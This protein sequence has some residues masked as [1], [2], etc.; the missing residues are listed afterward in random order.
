MNLVRNGEHWKFHKT[1]WCERGLI[2]SDIGT[3]NVREDELNTIL[4]YSMIRLENLQKAC[5]RGV[6]G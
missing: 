6:T 2:L 5:Q 1:V 4:G 3:K